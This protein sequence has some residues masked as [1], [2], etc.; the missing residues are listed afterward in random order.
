MSVVTCQTN[1]QI[2]GEGHNAKA[3]ELYAEGVRHANGGDK[4]KGAT[5]YVTLETLF[6]LAVVIITSVCRGLD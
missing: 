1:G 5:A 2:V 6:S 4:A 3:G